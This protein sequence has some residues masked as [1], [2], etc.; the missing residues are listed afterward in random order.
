MTFLEV[1]HVNAPA[2]DVQSPFK[3]IHIFA[4][5]MHLSSPKLLLLLPISLLATHSAEFG[6]PSPVPSLPS[7]PA[8]L[9]C[10]WAQQAL[11]KQNF[12]KEQSLLE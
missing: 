4:N 1:L 5:Y 3:Y 6:E 9:L 12:I 2:A 11:F 7:T 10:R 8:L